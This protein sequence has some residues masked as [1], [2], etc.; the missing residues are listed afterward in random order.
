KGDRRM[1]RV[2]AAAI[3]DRERAMPRDIVVRLDGYRL[4]LRRHDTARI[5]ERTRGR[6]GTHN[7]R[8]PYIAGL[9]LDHLR[10]EYRR[11]VVAAYRERSAV[12]DVGVAALLARGEAAPEEW[13]QD[14]TDRLRRAAE[15]KAALERMWPALSGA[16]L[17]NDLFG[18]EALV[19]SAARGVLDGDEQRL[20]VRE[21]AHD[22]RDV[23]WTDADV[24]L[25]DEADALLGP[26]R[27]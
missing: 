3:R 1:A 2:I 26:P 11:A 7:E 27:A 24:P 10:R 13:E 14:L 25:V 20:L 4:R 6:R 16:E 8:R 12:E 15:V 21:R 22:V 17:V 19:R 23:A 9:L 5:V 18:F